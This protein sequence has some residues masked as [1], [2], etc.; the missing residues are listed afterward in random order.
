M[1]MSDSLSD[2]ARRLLLAPVVLFGFASIIA[3][4]G[5]SRSND[6]TDDDEEEFDGAITLSPAG[7][8]VKRGQSAVVRVD[9]EGFPDGEGVSG[10]SIDLSEQLSRIDI[11]TAACPAGVGTRSCQ[12]WTISPLP[13]SIPGEYPLQIVGNG[14]PRGVESAELAIRV[15]DSATAAPARLVTDRLV[16]DTNGHLWATGLND[17]GQAGVGFWNGCDETVRHHRCLLPAS[18]DGYVRVGT[19][20]WI[21]AVATS[22]I[23]LAVRSDGTVWAWGN[24]RGDQLGFDSATVGEVV[25]RPRQLP[26]LERITRISVLMRGKAG[27]FARTFF[28]ALTQDGTVHSWGGSRNNAPTLVPMAVDPD[29]GDRTPLNDVVQIAGA[30]TGPDNGFGFA[31]AIRRDGSVWQWGGGYFVQFDGSTYTPLHMPG[32][33]NGLPDNIRSIAV[34]SRVVDDSI[35]PFALAAASDGSV[36]TWDEAEPT[37]VQVAGLADIA[38]VDANMGLG[39]AAALAS[40]GRVWHWSAVSTQPQ[41]VAGL[42]PIATL[43]HSS[44]YSA[45]AADCSSGGSLWAHFAGARRIPDFA[46]TANAGCSADAQVTLTITRAGEGTVATDPAYLTCG[47]VCEAL[48]PVMAGLRMRA[49][50]APGWELASPESGE[51]SDRTTLVVR[52]AT[53]CA[54]TFERVVPRTL[55]VSV[56]AGGRVISDPA[57][58]DCPIDCSHN[59]A[60]SVSSVRLTATAEL[61]Y[62]F[63][64][65]S[66]DEDCADG[67]VDTESAHH[68][69][70]VF[71]AFPVPTAPAGFVATPNARSVDLAWTGVTDGSIVRYQLERTEDGAAFVPLGNLDGTAASYRDEGVVPGRQ[72]TYRLIAINASGSSTPASATATVPTSISNTLT[73]QVTGA[74]SVS[75]APAGI[76]CPSDC[77]QAYSLITNVTL[78]ATATATSRFDGWTGDCAGT[79]PTTMVTVDANRTCG[80]RFVTVAGGGWQTLPGPLASSSE[81]EVRSVLTLDAAGLGYLAYLQQVG[82]QSRLS[83]RREGNNGIFPPLG[84]AFNANATWSAYSPN[85]LLDATGAAIV[86]F[87]I[88]LQ[89]NAVARWNAVTLQ[90]DLLSSRTNLTIGNASSVRMARSGNTLVLAWLEANQIAV[91]RYDLSAGQWDT[92]AFVP[93]VI[94]PSDI[95]LALDSSGLAVLGYSTGPLNTRLH[96]IRETGPGAWAALGGEIGTRPASGPLVMQFGIHVDTSN[97]VRIVWVDGDTNFTLSGAQFDGANWVALPGRGNNVVFGASQFDLRALSVNRNPALFAFAYAWDTSDAD[98]TNSDVF[99]Q[100]LLPDGMTQVG[101]TLTTTHPRVGHLSLAMNEADR[102]TL[103]QS[104]YTPATAPELYRLFIRRHAP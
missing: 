15:I 14:V 72:Y 18:I 69:N 30:T 34:G 74:G 50:P 94:N 80:A 53:T 61:G 84:L 6:I 98:D 26:G 43:G 58:I 20:T 55:S 102:A 1:R 19:E 2:T 78:T 65:F 86:A 27:Q 71:A 31:L 77:T 47:A 76:S 103:A 16:I 4:G 67:Q 38:T 88:D 57:G 49:T 21:D 56:S 75:S 81:T 59:Y 95:D 99:V 44:A 68:C 36:W 92:G 89:D 12:D 91:R 97:T 93:N 3:T 63:G 51:C 70:V 54:Y 52:T 64:A 28:L 66:G 8:T 33:V 25:I 9:V 5:G 22:D 39:A 7:V 96:A 10:Y 73:V 40:D 85:L 104:Q 79:A 101:S 62:R 13:D 100:Q 23:S 48:V 11:T 83:V 32:R 82:T 87:N 35:S 17:F 45:I 60:T 29:D 46:A 37:P 24:N 42:P 41:I 90:W